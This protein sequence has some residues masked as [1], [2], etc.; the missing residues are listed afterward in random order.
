MKP[1]LTLFRRNGSRPRAKPLASGCADTELSIHP[2]NQ[3]EDL[4]AFVTDYQKCAQ[5]IAQTLLKQLNLI[6]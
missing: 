4:K 2:L 5:Q 3:V 1:K 6:P